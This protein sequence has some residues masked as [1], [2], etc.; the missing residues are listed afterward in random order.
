MAKKGHSRI[1]SYGFKVT[2]I[3]L[4]SFVCVFLGIDL[5]TSGLERV[6]G[7]LT[8]VSATVLPAPTTAQEPVKASAAEQ[9]PEVKPAVASPQQ[10]IKPVQESLLN[11]ALIGLGDVLRYL[12]RGV[13]SFI[14]DLFSAIVH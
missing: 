4:L 2:C 5:A 7:P 3:A 1:S 9:E 12:A 6:Q 11:R 10:S 13:I 14:A 8:P